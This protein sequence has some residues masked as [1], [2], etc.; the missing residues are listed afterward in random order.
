MNQARDYH[1]HK[2]QAIELININPGVSGSD[3]RVAF[4]I[5]TRVINSDWEGYVTDAELAD[6]LN[7]SERTVSRSIKALV[8]ANIFKVRRGK[9]NRAS[10]YKF[11][12][13]FEKRVRA[14]KEKPDK[15]VTALRGQTPQ[16]R[17]FNPSNLSGI[18]PQACHPNKELRKKKDVLIRKNQL[19]NKIGISL[20]VLLPTS[21]EFEKWEANLRCEHGIVLREDISPMQSD[22]AEFYL[23]PDCDP[24]SLESRAVIQKFAEYIK[25]A[26]PLLTSETPIVEP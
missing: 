12:S 3:I 13:G 19:E 9:I 14:H 18:T 6:N 24:T 25:C 26:S 1:Q 11:T 23:F 16:I 7:I 8:A 15:S 17:S 2:L 20:K 22:G 5:L 10:E 4:A 21:F